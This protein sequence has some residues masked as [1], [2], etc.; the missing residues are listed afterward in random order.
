MAAQEAKTPDGWFNC[1]EYTTPDILPGPWD[2][3][4]RAKAGFTYLGLTTRSEGT[5]E[6]VGQ[7]LGTPLKKNECYHFTVALA[8]SSTYAGYNTAV[9]F[10]L[11]GGTSACNKKQLLVE[12]QVIDHYDWKVYTFYFFPDE[13]YQYIV[14]EPFYKDGKNYPYSG[15]ILID[16]FSTFS[17]C[18]RASLECPESSSPR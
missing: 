12:S 11:W 14:I 5:W 6:M 4:T 17:P 18:I 7:D 8:R 2:V 3:M 15:N 16:A 9:R 10:R 13:D 1:G